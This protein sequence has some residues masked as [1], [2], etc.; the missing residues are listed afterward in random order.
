MSGKSKQINRY[1]KYLEEK[2]ARFSVDSNLLEDI[3]SKATNENIESKERLI[4][5]EVNE[6]Y[7]IT[8]NNKQDLIVRISRSNKPRFKSEKWAIEQCRKIGVPTPEVLYVE[9]ISLD[10]Q[11][12]T[13][14]VEKKLKGTPLRTLLDESKVS[15]KDAKTIVIEAGQIL[16]K[17]HSVETNGFGQ[18]VSDG[19]GVFDTWDKFM[20]EW[21]GKKR[22]YIEESANKIDLD[23]KFLVKSLKILE[24]HKDLFAKFSPKLLHSD[25][26]PDHIFVN[27]GKISGI[28]D[29]ENAR[30]GDGVW[31]FSWWSFFWN[32]RPSIRWLEEGYKREAE[33]GEDYDLRLHLGKI[34]LGLDMV[35]YY[36]H[37]NH[38]TGI[39]SAK[40]K[41]KENLEYFK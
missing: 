13:F 31:D 34:K 15:K 29:F 10:E 8:T 24:S 25:F 5:G 40:N 36:Q 14:C 38:E 7:S 20:L 22:K 1:K 28:I 18:L 4:H 37:E 12:L 3:V 21:N 26:G 32:T 39:E 19:K 23:T 35:W 27:E 30:G 6:V 17:I 33:L 9:S 11:K 16:A 2:H 41:I